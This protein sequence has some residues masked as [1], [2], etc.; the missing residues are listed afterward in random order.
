M[1]NTDTCCLV[2][3]HDKSVHGPVSSLCA[4]CREIHMNDTFPKPN[5]EH[6]FVPE[7]S[8]ETWSLH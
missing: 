2:C 4:K 6:L 5:A 7:P 1:T 3:G 8:T